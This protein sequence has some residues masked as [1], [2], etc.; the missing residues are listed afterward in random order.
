MRSAVSTSPSISSRGRA[1]TLAMAWS[2][3]ARRRSTPRT[4][5][6]RSADLARVAKLRASR[7][8]QERGERAGH[9]RPS[10]GSGRRHAAGSGTLNPLSRA[11]E[12]SVDRLA[13]ASSRGLLRAGPSR[14]TPRCRPRRPSESPRL[15]GASR[16]VPGACSVVSPGIASAPTMRSLARRAPPTRRAMG[17]I[18]A[19]ALRA[20]RAD[21]AGSQRP[22]SR[23]SI[24]ARR[25]SRVILRSGVIDPAAS[26][27]RVSTSRRRTVLRESREERRRMLPGHDRDASL[28][29]GC[30][31][32]PGLRRVESSSL[33]SRLPAGERPLDRRRT[34]VARGG[35]RSGG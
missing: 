30:R 18:R 14:P 8:E 26:P 34:A 4:I 35:A 3:R 20:A 22:C 7:L 21:H 19:R 15:A 31:R 9:L 10:S 27:A 5:S 13:R 32:C 11:E 17:R 12:P 24:G 6:V 2:R 1:D 16:T 33:P 29:A 23:V 25:R 28:P